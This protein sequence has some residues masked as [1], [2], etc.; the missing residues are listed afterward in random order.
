MRSALLSVFVMTTLLRY[1]YSEFVRKLFK[2]RGICKT[3]CEPSVKN[4]RVEMKSLHDAMAY[5]TAGKPD[6]RLFAFTIIIVFEAYA[7]F[8]SKRSDCFEIYRAC[9]S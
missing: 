4:A 7:Q 8:Y 2:Y 1:H 5:S 9:S 3:S 6:H